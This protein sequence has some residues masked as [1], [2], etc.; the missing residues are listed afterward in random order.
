METVSIDRFEGEIAVCERADY[1]YIYFNKADLPAGVKPGS[2]LTIS[3]S[4]LITLDSHEEMKRK[5]RIT[6]LYNSI[7]KKRLTLSC[8]IEI[9]KKTL[10][11]RHRP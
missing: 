10:A 7:L 3:D 5:R 6:D 8:H 9:I 11:L 2:I 1:T 4:G